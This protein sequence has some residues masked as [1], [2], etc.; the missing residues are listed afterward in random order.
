MSH[1]AKHAALPVRRASGGRAAHPHAAWAAQQLVEALGP[2]A[3]EVV[4]LIRDRDG[5]FGRAFDSRVDKL[6]VKQFRTAV[7]GLHHRYAR[8]G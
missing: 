3:P 8:V 5:I 6:G 1:P 2:D 4:R 7:G